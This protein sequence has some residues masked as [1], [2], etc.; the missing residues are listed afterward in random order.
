MKTNETGRSMVE[1]LG[2]LAIIGVLSVA[3]IAGYTQAMKK[4]KVN[5]AVA[6]ISMAVILAKTSN[7]GEGLNGTTSSTSCATLGFSGK[8][9]NTCT[10]NH[11][12]DR[13]YN[14]SA[15][16][17]KDSSV[18]CGEVKKVA[19]SA[20]DSAASKAGYYVSCN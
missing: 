19:P 7:G 9:L 18:T 20:N 2:V 17:F 4:N 12:S 1:M 6:D 15:A 11:V 10:I 14:V 8:Y 16:T 3:G 5:N 13:V